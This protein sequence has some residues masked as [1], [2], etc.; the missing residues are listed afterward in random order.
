MDKEY[1]LVLVEWVDS[2]GCSV[3][4]ANM[5]DVRV[6]LTVCH[7]AG[8]LVAETDEA[9]VIVPHVARGEV[10]I[11]EGQGCGDMTIPKVAVKSIVDL[12]PATGG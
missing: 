8:Y 10:V 9:V 11:P 3:N 2:H 7:S 6:A 4:W 12:V 5:D 1:R